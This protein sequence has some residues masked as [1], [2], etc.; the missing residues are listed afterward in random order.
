MPTGFHQVCENPAVLEAQ[1]GR[2]LPEV[3]QPVVEGSG[4]SHPHVS[5]WLGGFPAPTVQ[6]GGGPCWGSQGCALISPAL[7][8]TPFSS[9]TVNHNF[10]CTNPSTLPRGSQP[11]S[12]RTT[13]GRR[14]QRRREH[15]SSCKTWSVPALLGCLREI[16]P[17]V[18]DILGHGSACAYRGC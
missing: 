12:P 7:S 18:G 2:D 8:S 1:R 17:R 11:M 13:M 5:S 15:K 14:R 3:T 4:G 6:Q 9:P 10:S 16:C